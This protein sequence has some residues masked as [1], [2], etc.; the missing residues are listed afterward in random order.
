V[1]TKRGRGES[2]KQSSI[3]GGSAVFRLHAR[4]EEKADKRSPSFKEVQCG[5]VEYIN[6]ERTRPDE[7]RAQVRYQQK[8]GEVQRRN[9]SWLAGGLRLTSEDTLVG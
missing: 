4:G 2:V 6:P 5:Q 9:R 8:A 7:V 3:S 1:I